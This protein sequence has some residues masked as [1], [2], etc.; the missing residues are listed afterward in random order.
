LKLE[1]AIENARRIKR[2][3]EERGS[4]HGWLEAH[5]P[6]SLEEWTLLFRKTFR[7]TGGKIVEEFLLSLGYLEGAHERDCPVYARILALSPPWA[8]AMQPRRAISSS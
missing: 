4:F 8:R 1:A 5:H 2:L 3:R 6:R 7:F